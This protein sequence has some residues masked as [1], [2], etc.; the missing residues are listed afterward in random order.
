MNKDMRTYDQDLER[1]RNLAEWMDN[2]FHIPGTD[3][4]FGLDSLI[5]LLPGVG[6]TVTLA[7]TAYLL[8][9]ASSYKLPI[10]VHLKIL[11]NGFLDWLVGLVP[12]L[13]DIFDIG[14]KSNLKNVEL[15]RK[16][17]ENAP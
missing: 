5:G 12:V 3:I 16:H 7:S 14:W 8:G 1:L 2:R 11:L 9:K 4:R 17:I 13:G 6:D 15:I 10:S